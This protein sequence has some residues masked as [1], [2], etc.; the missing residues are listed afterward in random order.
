MSAFYDLASLVLVPS[1]YKA[2]KVYAQKP[3]TTDGQL[4]FSRASTATR[5]NSAGLIETV[6]SN[7]PRLDYLGSTCP[8]LQLEPSRTNAITWSENVASCLTSQVGTTVAADATTSPDGTANADKITFGSGNAYRLRGETVAAS[9]TYTFS[10]FIKND[11]FSGSEQVFINLSDGVVGGLTATYVP[12]QATITVV[13]S[14]GAWTGVSGKVENYGNGWYRV[15]ATGTSVGGGS[16]WFEVA[17]VN[18][19]K[20]AFFW[21]FSLEIGAYATSYIPTTTAAVTRLADTMSKTLVNS[22]SN[23]SLFL[24][25]DEAPLGNASGD[26]LALAPSNALGRAYMYVNSF[27]FADAYGAAASV[28]AQ[29][30]FAWTQISSTTAKVFSNGVLRSTGTT[31][32]YSNP[33]NLFSI[34]GNFLDKPVRIKQLMFF[35]APITDAQAI[36]LTTL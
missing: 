13:G 20:A 33:F 21:G 3:L 25:L 9:T 18:T 5:V 10:V 36:E 7:V 2:S 31:G 14:A 17:T 12:A 35:D 26:W 1:G 34:N 29:R 32:S 6:S 22:N 16:G 28:V 8:K 11:T 27:G 23:F 4:T 19:P 24:E 30:K 15:I